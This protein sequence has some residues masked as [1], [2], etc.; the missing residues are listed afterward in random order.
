MAL[1]SATNFFSIAKA[2][3]FINP[4]PQYFFDMEPLC[5]ALDGLRMFQFSIG[6][7]F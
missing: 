7:F 1:G 4:T 6:D 5:P 3:T 2:R